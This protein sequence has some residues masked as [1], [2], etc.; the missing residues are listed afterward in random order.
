MDRS[1]TTDDADDIALPPFD[2]SKVMR[3]T[4]AHRQGEQPEDEK[5]AVMFW[6]SR[7]FAVDRLESGRTLFSRDSDF[8]LSRDSAPLA[9]CEVKTVW[10]HTVR[11]R[12]LHED[13][14]IEERVEVS[15]KT[16]QER[17]ST[18]LVTA[19]RQLLYANPDHALLNFVLLVNRDQE[20]TLTDLLSVLNTAFSSKKTKSLAARQAIWTAK[21]IDQFRR[22]VDLCLW[23]SA[24][25]EELVLD[26]CL[27]FNPSLLSLAAEITGLRGDRLI[28][29]EP[30]A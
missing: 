14:P 30:A 27:L 12:I 29:L 10:R 1:L 16:V 11:T 15:N 22:N 9:F 20:A 5:R 4:F 13:R 28:S 8:R 21:E 3:G 25:G 23:S 2:R 18:D 19:I 17:L 6:E 7:G 26:Q 24:A